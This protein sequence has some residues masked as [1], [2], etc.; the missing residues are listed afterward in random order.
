MDIAPGTHACLV[1]ADDESRR[2]SVAAFLAFALQ[3]DGCA[4]YFETEDAGAWLTAALLD[5]GVEA[6]ALEGDR[7]T[8]TRAREVYLPEGRFVS[9][10]MLERLRELHGD[11]AERCSGPIH[12]S[13]EMG[14]ALDAAAVDAEALIDYERRV[15]GV[16]AH[17]PL[18]AVCQ[19]DATAFAPALIYEVVRVHPYLIVDGVV[20]P[21][22][23]YRGAPGPCPA[24]GPHPA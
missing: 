7:L 3:R 23:Q 22:G 20:V 9:Q 17:H 11:L 6:D 13:G 1:Y 12:I 4:R 2:R 10:R 21:N 18:S 16:V 24:C 14:W 19:Y 15:N 8:R 5:A